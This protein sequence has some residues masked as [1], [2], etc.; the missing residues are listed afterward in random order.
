MAASVPASA[1]MTAEELYALDDDQR[2]D[3]LEGELLQ[4]SPAGRRHGKVGMRIGARVNDFVEEHNLG[5]VYTA[6]T[7][8][9]LRRNPD[10]VLGPD[11]SFVYT[12]RVPPEDEEGF[13]N[14]APDLAVEVVSPSN[15]VREMTAKVVAYLDAGARQVWVVEPRRR[16]VTVYAADG[17]A[18]LLREGDT[19]DG[20]EVLPEFSLPVAEIFR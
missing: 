11:V 3:L 9:I 19:I 16:I 14:L 1:P 18:R 12:E 17:N 10:T 6:E 20:G 8:F 15:T 13:L 5:E 4:M 2:Y 7:G